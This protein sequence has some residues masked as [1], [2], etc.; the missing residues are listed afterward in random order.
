MESQ[1]VP[2]A[3]QRLADQV[4]TLADNAET[5]AAQAGQLGAIRRRSDALADD[6]LPTMSEQNAGR[7]YGRGR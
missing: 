4:G 6:I 5:L 2:M 3:A 7:Q 1:T